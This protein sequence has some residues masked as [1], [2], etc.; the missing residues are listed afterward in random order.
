[1]EEPEQFIFQLSCKAKK[2]QTASLFLSTS[3]QHYKLHFLPGLSIKSHNTYRKVLSLDEQTFPGWEEAGG[4]WPAC[5]SV[6]EGFSQQGSH[7]LKTLQCQIQ[8]SA[9]EQARNNAE[10]NSI[11]TTP[12]AQLCFVSSVAKGH[13]LL[14]TLIT[15]GTAR[16]SLV[17]FTCSLQSL[18]SISTTCSSQSLLP[19]VVFPLLRNWGIGFWMFF[20]VTWRTS[21]AWGCFF[22]FFF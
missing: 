11:E 14:L 13:C 8:Q 7:N 16:K 20:S 1:M 3:L 2:N 15:C 17:I 12:R 19:A 4:T 6:W 9:E 18:C 22:F 5:K 21:V 10:K